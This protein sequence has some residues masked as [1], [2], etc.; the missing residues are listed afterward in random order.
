VEL[1]HFLAESS[2]IIFTHS[3]Q[4]SGWSG[5]CV[6]L[7]VGRAEYLYGV[8]KHPVFA[9]SQNVAVDDSVVGVNLIRL[10]VPDTAKLIHGVL[11]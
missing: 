9:Q 5:G 1:L 8:D 7:S 2:Q 4:G 11:L 10:Q 3:D 6:Q